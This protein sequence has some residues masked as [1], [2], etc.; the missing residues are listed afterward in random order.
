MSAVA[1]HLH[2]TSSAATVK[3]PTAPAVKTAPLRTKAG[4]LR[5]LDEDHADG[6]CVRNPEYETFHCGPS[7]I[8]KANMYRN[9]DLK[10]VTSL[11]DAALD[12]PA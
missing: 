11:V 4:H 10:R 1:D 9:Y 5:S 8:V 3:P 2:R 7:F 6:E 12:R